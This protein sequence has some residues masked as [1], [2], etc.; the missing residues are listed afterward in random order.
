M[1]ETSTPDCLIDYATKYVTDLRNF[2]PPNIS[3]INNRTPNEIVEGNTPDIL[4]FIRFSWFSFVWYWDP[5][6]F[7]KQH[8]GRWIGVAHSIGSGHV[9]YILTKN[10]RVLARSTVSNLSD[11]DKTSTG[12]QTQMA[13]F[14]ENIR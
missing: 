9:Y 12:I 8:I 10:G 7:K 3:S 4:E 11:D 1:T 5:A 14:D 13:Q 2:V 6:H